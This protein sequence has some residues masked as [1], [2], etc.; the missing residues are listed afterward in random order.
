MLETIPAPKRGTLW[1]YMQQQRISDAEQ[2]LIGSS[3]LYD[4][5]EDR[6]Q[7]R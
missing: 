3:F 7:D 2:R 1:M 4:L 6:I 5:K